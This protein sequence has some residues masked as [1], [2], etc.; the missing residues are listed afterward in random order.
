MSAWRATLLFPI[1]P[2]RAAH[3]PSV[4]RPG[5]LA[6]LLPALDLGIYLSLRGCSGGD[7]AVAA[8]AM[9]LAIGGLGVGGALGSLAAARLTE[10]TVGP[11]RRLGQS[12]LFAAWAALLFLFLICCGLLFG[13]G[14]ASPL[15]AAL[16]LLAWGVF[17]G[18][19]ILAGER[20]AEAG[21]ALVA[22]CVGLSGALAGLWLALTLV[23]AQF[24]IVVPSPEN[25]KSLLVRR[26]GAVRTACVTLQEAADGSR[27]RLAVW[28]AEGR[29]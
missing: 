10:S 24:L 23:Q 5:L 18:A 16:I 11:V 2:A 4:H 21:R 29:F 15:L 25:A 12:F 3:Q 19:A 20:Q 8:V 6:P 14:P 17:A 27:R 22:S 13:A 26:Q 9:L 28:R 1:R 7:A